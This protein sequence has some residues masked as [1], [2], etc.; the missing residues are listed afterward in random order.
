MSE[1]NVR[2]LAAMDITLSNDQERWIRKLM[3]ICD[4]T[5]IVNRTLLEKGLLV[6]LQP[7]EFRYYPYEDDE[8][9]F[10]FCMAKPFDGDGE[11]FSDKCILRLPAYT[12][13]A[14]KKHMLGFVQFMSEKE[15]PGFLTLGVSQRGGE[16]N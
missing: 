1:I 3:E 16:N 4:D 6:E 7:G 12:G 9:I 2:H 10:L 11:V 14:G 15:G 5:D 13:E 8:H